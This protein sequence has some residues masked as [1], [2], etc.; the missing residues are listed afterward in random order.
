MD[1]K[2]K[3]LTAFAPLPGVRVPR[4]QKVGSR[5][6]V[7]V[8][9]SAFEGRKSIEQQRTID[10]LLAAPSSPLTAEERRSIALVRPFSPKELRA[11]VRANRAR[12]Q[13]RKH[14][15]PTA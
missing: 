3:L 1:L 9:S 13:K 8:V 7:Y 5:W 15:A 6:I 14:T 11:L 12:K 2:E 10:D 4:M